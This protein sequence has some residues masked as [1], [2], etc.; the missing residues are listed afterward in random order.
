MLYVEAIA[1]DCYDFTWKVKVACMQLKGICSNKQFPC[2]V[3][4]DVC[5]V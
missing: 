2:S 5:F 3:W 1:R 4:D